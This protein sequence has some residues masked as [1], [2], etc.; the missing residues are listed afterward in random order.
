ME[1]RGTETTFLNNLTEPAAPE[2][3]RL[4]APP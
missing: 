3:D 1:V 4:I 2:P